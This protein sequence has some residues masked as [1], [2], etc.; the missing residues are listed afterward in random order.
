MTDEEQGDK[1]LI[2]DY[3]GKEDETD[4]AEADGLLHLLHHRRQAVAQRAGHARDGVHTVGVVNEQRVDE[5]PT[6]SK[7]SVYYVSYEDKS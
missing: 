7:E 6:I 4:D 1:N 5:V 3:L 2:N